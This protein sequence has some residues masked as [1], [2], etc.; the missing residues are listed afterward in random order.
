MLQSGHGHSGGRVKKIDYRESEQRR[1]SFCSPPVQQKS[2]VKCLTD[3]V[4]DLSQPYL[5]HTAAKGDRPA[6]PTLSALQLLATKGGG[7][8][9]TG[10]NRWESPMRLAVG[11]FRCL[12]T[13][14]VGCIS[15]GEWE[16]GLQHVCLLAGWRKPFPVYIMHFGDVGCWL[17]CCLF[18]NPIVLPFREHFPYYSAFEGILRNIQAEQYPQPYCGILAPP[19]LQA[20]DSHTRHQS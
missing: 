18:C 17:L 5:M 6:G 3:G 14:L 8:T 16:E 4:Q 12:F 7:L 15:I 1:G 13:S 20:R 10:N 19:Q 9:T 11:R 2:H